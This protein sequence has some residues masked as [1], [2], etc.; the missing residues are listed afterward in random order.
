[1]MEYSAIFLLGIQQIQQK[2]IERDIVDAIN[3]G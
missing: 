2:A 3:L 1:M